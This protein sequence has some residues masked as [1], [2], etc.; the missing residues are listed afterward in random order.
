MGVKDSLLGRSVVILVVLLLAFQGLGGCAGPEKEP[1][2]DCA[3]LSLSPDRLG[4]A[5]LVTWAEM[6]ALDVERPRIDDL[7]VSFHL[8]LHTDTLEVGESLGFT[9]TI[10]N[11]TDDA[12][13]L[14]FPREWVSVDPALGTFV[15]L[16]W[17][18]DGFGVGCR[19]A[20]YE[21]PPWRYDPENFIELPARSRCEWQ[22]RLV[23]DDVYCPL[24]EVPEPGDYW[25]AYFYQSTVV[26]P[27]GPL[28]QDPLA[29][30]T[31]YDVEAVIGMTQSNHVKF[32][33][34]ESQGE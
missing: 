11:E 2:L 17:S 9:L 12:V 20:T 8:S 23:W 31:F 19:S 3:S 26:G 27:R 29:E 33:I 13:V 14:N 22:S 24:D 18:Q 6:D 34:V 21:D 4:S 10:A 7:P 30:Y 25:I 28:A 1:V 16:V 5:P 15:L 32:A